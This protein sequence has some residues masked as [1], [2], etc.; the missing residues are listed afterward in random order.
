VALI[1]PESLA[2]IRPEWVALIGPEYSYGELL[3]SNAPD[4]TNKVIAYF[5]WE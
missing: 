3:G 5:G 4:L 1:A 2:L